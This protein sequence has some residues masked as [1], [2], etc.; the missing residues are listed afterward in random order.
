LESTR[1]HDTIS[2]RERLKRKDNPM[3]A[4][5]TQVQEYMN[6]KSERT[7]MDVYDF[8]QSVYEFC[9]PEGKEPGEHA[10]NVMDYYEMEELGACLKQ[11]AA[12]LAASQRPPMP[13]R[14]TLK[15]LE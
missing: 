2:R 5:D 11:A 6:T 12:E 9:I 13:I 3:S 8:L 1:P 15:E 7:L 4:F 14:I 10:F